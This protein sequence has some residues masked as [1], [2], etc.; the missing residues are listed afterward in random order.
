MTKTKVTPIEQDSKEK[1]VDVSRRKSGVS[2]WHTHRKGSPIS[3][4]RY[5]LYPKGC[6][7]RPGTVGEEG[8]VRG[9]PYDG[10]LRTDGLQRHLWVTLRINSRVP[11]LVRGTR[12]RGPEDTGERSAV[13]RKSTSHCCIDLGGPPTDDGRRAGRSL[14]TGRK[15][16]P[17]ITRSLKLN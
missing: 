5:P 3:G 16:H 10:T 13:H 17:W 8:A 2:P 15:G 12:S 4:T 7:L 1:R 6:H 11:T 9:T 14:Y